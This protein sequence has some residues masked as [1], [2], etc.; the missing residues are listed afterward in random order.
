MLCRA[1]LCVLLNIQQTV[2]PGMIQVPGTIYFVRAVFSSHV[3]PF[4]TWHINKHLAQG[5]QL[6]TSTSWQT[7]FH[8]STFSLLSSTLYWFFHFVNYCIFFVFQFFLR[9]FFTIS[10]KFDSFELVFH[11]P[12]IFNLFYFV[13]LLFFSKFCFWELNLQLRFFGS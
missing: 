9:S 2:V 7:L 12:N 13:F 6:C 10:C 11:V 8:R 1:T 4:R 5:N 3:L